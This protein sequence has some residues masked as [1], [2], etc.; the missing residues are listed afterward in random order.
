MEKA[1]Q[2]M[3]DLRAFL[4]EEGIGVGRQREGGGG[5]G[6]GLRSVQVVRVAVSGF[7]DRGGEE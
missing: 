4:S 3:Q 5:E 1:M 6:R 2:G 7:G